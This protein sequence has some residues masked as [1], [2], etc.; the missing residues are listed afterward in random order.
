MM[1]ALIFLVIAIITG[2]LGFT[3][4][5]K[6][7]AGLTRVLFLISVV[8]FVIFLGLAVMAEEMSI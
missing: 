8:I 6:T 1:W 3:S 5:A 2:G 4:L 7:S